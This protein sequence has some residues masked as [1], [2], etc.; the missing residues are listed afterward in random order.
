MVSA[1]WVGSERVSRPEGV[2]L[3][4]GGDR[5]PNLRSLLATLERRGGEVFF[6][7]VGGDH[8]PWI[9]WDLPSD[10]LVVDG[11][12]IAPRAAFVRH[13]VFTHLADSRP[14]SAH[15]AFAWY[16][17]VASWI[18]A[19]GAVRGLNRRSH[20]PA[21]LK[22]HA[23]HLA[24]EVGL[25]IPATRITNHLESL[26]GLAPGEPKVVKPVNGG[27]YCER[28]E[29]VLAKTETRDGATAAPAIAQPEL[30]QPEVR[31]YGVGGRFLAFAMISEDLD[32][33]V[34]QS[35]RVE[36]LPE[37]PAGLADGMA[38]LMERMGLDFGA[39]DFKTDRQTGELLFLEMNT[40]P[41]FAAFDLASD[42]A[43]SEAIAD[44]LEG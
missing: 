44:F 12:E 17:T 5:D 2:I 36:L 43:V 3:V 27:G 34:R 29:E 22:P 13:D 30:V 19:H 10:R 41:M 15:R 40:S 4:A 1:R 24:R 11:R 26:A 31:V 14:A 6:L 20:D 38:R 23:L 21:A 18:A 39:A 28:L 7:A 35:A 33:R 9:L 42:S 32:Y 25:T 8:H 16:T 37:V